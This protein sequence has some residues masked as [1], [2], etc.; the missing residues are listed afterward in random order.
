MLCALY[1]M[2]SHTRTE[3]KLDTPDIN[4]KYFFTGRFQAVLGAVSIH[5]RTIPTEWTTLVAKLVSTLADK[6]CHVVS[7]TDP[8]GGIQDFIDRSRYFFLR[9]ARQLHSRG[10]VNLV[11]DP[12]LLRKYGSAGNRTRNLWVCRQELWPLD[13]RSG[14]KD[15]HS[16]KHLKMVLVPKHVVQRQRGKCCALDGIWRNPTPHV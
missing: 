16:C 8:H 2:S 15:R 4:M 3:V 10:R 14:R 9:V 6:G 12:L 13:H 5:E 11:P 1:Y 7:V